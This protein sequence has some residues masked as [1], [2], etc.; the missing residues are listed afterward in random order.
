MVLTVLKFQ[1]PNPSDHLKKS[2]KKMYVAL[3]AEDWLTTSIKLSKAI[4]K[5]LEFDQ[6]NVTIRD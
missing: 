6:A 2:Q 5:R 3:A 4:H 1:S